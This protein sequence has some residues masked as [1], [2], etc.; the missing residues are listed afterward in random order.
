MVVLG[1]GKWVYQKRFVGQTNVEEKIYFEPAEA[2]DS[3]VPPE[4]IAELD[5]LAPRLNPMQQ[6]L[7][8][9]MRR[10]NQR[11]EVVKAWAFAAALTAMGHDTDAA[12]VR[13]MQGRLKRLLGLRWWAYY[14]QPETG[15]QRVTVV[16][17]GLLRDPKGFE[18]SPERIQDLEFDLDGPRPRKDRP[19]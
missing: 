14:A 1:P 10:A 6:D 19:L 4:L 3:E 18:R 13:Q 5:M 15:Q 2:P 12:N 17:G 9:L 7:L 16:R 11:S 8:K